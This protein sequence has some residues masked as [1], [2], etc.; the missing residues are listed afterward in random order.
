MN[1]QVNVYAIPDLHTAIDE[2]L[3]SV[4]S[5]LGYNDNYRLIDMKL[6]IGYSIA[7]VAGISFILDRKFKWE[8][9]LIYQKFLV[10]LYAILSAIF[11][12]FMN[13]VERGVVYQGDN[14][15]ESI[16]IK[17]EFKKNE[18]ICEVTF[19]DGNGKEMVS[20]LAAVN[21]FNEYGYLQFNALFSWFEEQVKLLK[22]KKE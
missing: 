16:I 7:A 3:P 13:F 15:E 11:W 6:A 2:A 14:N 9:V 4:F 18:P 10:G 22:S 8:E 21:V 19:I 5:R 17:T 12:V 1:K 20:N